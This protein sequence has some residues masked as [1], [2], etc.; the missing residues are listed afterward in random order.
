MALLM[1]KEAGQEPDSR[2]TLANERTALAWVRTSLALIAAGV[3][4]ETLG[5]GLNPTLRIVASI[6]LLSVGSV[7]PIVA[8]YQW[9][10]TQNALR[11][12]LPLPRG[13][14]L[15]IVMMSSVITGLILVF[16]VLIS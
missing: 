12:E 11:M 1:I 13:P 3:A 2:F 9:R 6:L 8:W 16:G 5:L 14:A 10:K 7:L 4:L 15:L